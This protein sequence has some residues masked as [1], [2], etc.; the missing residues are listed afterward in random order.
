MY[1]KKATKKTPVNR[2][3]LV[4]AVLIL[5]IIGGGYYVMSRP[6][7]TTV[8]LPDNQKNQPIATAVPETNPATANENTQQPE[9][10]SAPDEKSSRPKDSKMKNPASVSGKETRS[11]SVAN[12]VSKPTSNEK[13]K[14]NIP[15]DEESIAKQE[16]EI[17]QKQKTAP[18]PAEKKK[19]LGDV[20]K[21][22]FT[23]KEKKEP[24]KNNELV[25]EEPRPADNR[26]ATH[27]QNDN[28]TAPQKNPAEVNT[29][30]LATMIDLTSNAPDNWMMGIKNL[31]ITLRNRSEATLQSASVQVNYYNENNELLEKKMIYFSNVAPKAKAT[32]AAPDH[33]F[34]DHVD[35]KLVTVS[36]K[37]DRYAQN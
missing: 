4:I 2:K 24:A 26:Q 30:A 9:S 37:E 35:F 28:N 20:I 1:Q 27:R 36:A 23:K 13:T 7:V 21:N 15:S 3:D 16:P 31:K 29:A 8:V 12:P 25:L 18:A 34:A 10:V 11:V 33:K 6:S 22:I 17:T 14:P 5:A 19:K 32:V